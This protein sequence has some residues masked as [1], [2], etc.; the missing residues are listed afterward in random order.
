MATR[1]WVV[2]AVAAAFGAWLLAGCV[3]GGGEAA[4]AGSVAVEAEPARVAPGEALRL[5]GEGFSADCADNPSAREGPDRGVRVE[6]RQ[7]P[8]TWDLATV[9]AD[10]DDSFE[11]ELE[12][13]GNAK[14]GRAVVSAAGNMGEARDG[15]LVSGNAS[16]GKPAAPSDERAGGEETTLMAMGAADECGSGA[17]CA[18]G[19]NPRPVPDVVGETVPAACRALAREGYGGQV[20]YEKKSDEFEPGRIVAQDVEPGTRDTTQLVVFLTVAAPYPDRVPPNAPCVEVT[21]G[22]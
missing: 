13:P 10:P 16:G 8:R 15:V 6:L 1:S 17:A 20:Y 4:C 12:V 14:P 19:P 18:P 9:S 21:V 22:H 11:V 2:A 7:G 5:R 3:A